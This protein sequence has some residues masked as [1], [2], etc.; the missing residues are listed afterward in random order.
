MTEPVQATYGVV[1]S[2]V[3]PAN[4]PPETEGIEVTPATFGSAVSSAEPGD[5]LLL[6]EGT[7][8]DDVTVPEG[9]P[10]NPILLKPYAQQAVTI[11]GE[12]TLSSH[13][14]LAGITIDRRSDAW[15]LRIESNE[16]TAKMDIEV[17]YCEIFGGRTEAV[18]LQAN[19]VEMELHHCVI[20]TNGN[21]G[22]LSYSNASRWA[23]TEVEIHHNVLTMETLRGS[24]DGIQL[25]GWGY[26]HIHHNNFRDIPGENGI[27]IKEPLVGPATV[28]IEF[29]YFDGHSI[30]QA[31]ILTHAGSDGTT[32][33]RDNHFDGST[34][35][36][37]AIVLGTSSAETADPI[38]FQWNILTALNDRRILLRAGE[39]VIFSHNHVEGGTL[40]IGQQTPV[41]VSPRDVVISHNRFD[42]TAAS[43]GP[44]VSL[45]AS[46]D[47][48]LN[49][50]TGDWSIIGQGA[51]SYPAMDG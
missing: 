36:R 30:E 21:H 20:D 27:D 1:E 10:N 32:M 19:I 11:S 17:R 33:I 16:D 51:A 31:M 44:N 2:T 35:A 46:S 8:I 34:N 39:N 13:N 9:A 5:V 41:N 24:E 50:V 4:E 45:A 12:I 38:D 6:R 3:G 40:Q 42:G 23:P 22:V 28:E 37:N 15:A 47:N 29:N 25:N 26:H 48:E 43:F 49:Q 14:V 18:R 7:Y